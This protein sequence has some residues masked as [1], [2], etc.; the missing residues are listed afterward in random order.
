MEFRSTLLASAKR[1]F[2]PISCISAAYLPARRAGDVD[3]VDFLRG[4]T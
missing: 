1:L 2:A 4:A 3:P